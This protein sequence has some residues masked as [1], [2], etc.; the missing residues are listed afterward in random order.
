MMFYKNTKAIVCSPDEETL[1][2]HCRWSQA[3]KYISTKFVYILLSLQ[4]QSAGAA[5]Y[6]D[7]ISAERQ[8]FPNE[9]PGI[10]Y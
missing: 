1:L 9:C 7:S 5:E 8:D 4:A 3:R 6:S 2:Q 10:W